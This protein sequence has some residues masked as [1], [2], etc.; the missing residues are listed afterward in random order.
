MISADHPVQHLAD[1]TEPEGGRRLWLDGAPEA[2]SGSV[3]SA[4]FSHG[5]G[6]CPELGLRYKAFCNEWPE[7][8]VGVTSLR[9]H[10]CRPNGEVIVYA[11]VSLVFCKDAAARSVDIL[12]CMGSVSQA[13]HNLGLLLSS[14]SK[15]P[16]A[17][18]FLYGR[19]LALL[20]RIEVRADLRGEGLGLELCQQLI[21]ILHPRFQASLI[22]LNPFPLQF[23]GKLEAASGA[24]LRMLKQEFRL[25]QQRLSRLYEERLGAVPLARYDPHRVIL[26]KPGLQL[27]RDR[28]GWW[29]YDAGL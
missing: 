6:R 9:A 13:L 16:I 24:K 5:K 8:W 3:T 26:L 23:A 15:H 17:K 14:T 20:E 1:G 4:P 21:A 10:W 2:L 28:A 22:V 27:R 18:L 29:L 12:D 25:A 19:Q 7:N 11:D